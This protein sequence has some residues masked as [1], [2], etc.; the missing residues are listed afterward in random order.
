MAS[1]RDLKNLM[2]AEQI[3][4]TCGTCRS[5]DVDTKTSTKP[6]YCGVTGSYVPN[7]RVIQRTCPLLNNSLRLQDE[8][9]ISIEYGLIP[10]GPQA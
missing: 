10:M 5:L 1:N 9:L 6:Y 7:T 8:A 2:L 3:G 4:F